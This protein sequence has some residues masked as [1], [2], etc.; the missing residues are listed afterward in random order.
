M[1]KVTSPT[2]LRQS[3]VPLPAGLRNALEDFAADEASAAELDAVGASL[4]ALGLPIDLPATAPATPLHPTVANLPGGA[5]PIL[6]ASKSALASSAL[7]VG[8]VAAALAVG[9]A[10]GALVIALA[11]VLPSSEGERIAHPQTSARPHLG[12]LGELARPP[13]SEPRAEPSLPRAT[14]MKR[15]D[16]PEGSDSRMSAASSNAAPP[17]VARQ[18]KGESLSP[19]VPPLDG[20]AAASSENESELALLARAQRALATEP[21]LALQLAAAHERQFSASQLAQEREVIEVQA[22][23]QLG[24]RA[25]AQARAEAFRR[26]FPH[27]AHARRIDVILG[28]RNQ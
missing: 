19:A 7:S 2:R 27:S 24:R 25:E 28:K 8:S 3:S 18:G 1:T 9:V 26:R 15:G 14:G 4:R 21:A 12:P 11:G 23:V 17:T 22:L 16:S 5:P 10:S 6:A 20:V 13:H